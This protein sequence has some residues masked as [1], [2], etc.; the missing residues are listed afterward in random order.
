M[1]H[2]A[3]QPYKKEL[4][5]MIKLNRNKNERIAKQGIRELVSSIF[6]S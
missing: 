4:K 2:R 3:P 5:K 6:Q 1:K